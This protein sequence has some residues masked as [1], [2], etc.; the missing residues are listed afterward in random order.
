[1]NG[2]QTLATSQ[3]GPKAVQPMTQGEQ[4]MPPHHTRPRVTHDHTDLSP[5][6]ALVTVHRTPGAGRLARSEPAPLQPP[7]G[8]IQESSALLAQR[9][10]LAMVTLAI[11]PDHRG[12][13][14]PFTIQAP[15]R[16]SRR[17]ARGS[18]EGGRIAGRRTGLRP[19]PFQARLGSSFHTARLGATDHSSH[20][21]RP[22]P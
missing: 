2:G 15:S 4:R 6:L 7:T 10:A 17:A 9:P 5:P 11:V 14:P 8:I 16:R 1:M 22:P 3:L 19:A 18:S 12:H 21:P 13:R 20:R